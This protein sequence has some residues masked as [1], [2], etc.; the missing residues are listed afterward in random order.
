MPAPTHVLYYPPHGGEPIRVPVAG[1]HQDGRYILRH[2]TSPHN[3]DS[4]ITYSASPAAGQCGPIVNTESQSQIDTLT[5]T[6]AT[7]TTTLATR[8]SERDAAL[9]NAIRLPTSWTTDV[10]TWG[11]T[12]TTGSDW[13]NSKLTSLQHDTGVNGP[14]ITLATEGGLPTISCRVN[15]NMQPV[16]SATHKRSEV[17]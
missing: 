4:L 16:A 2:S 13:Q 9:V 11:G 3:I 14:G 7:L 1:V 12:L 15:S 6:N 8:T 10:W 17:V 5:A